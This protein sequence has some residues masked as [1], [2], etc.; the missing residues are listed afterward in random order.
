MKEYN[1]GLY[2]RLSHEDIEDNNSIEAQRVI[3][4]EY[5]IKHKYNI[6]DEYVDNGYSGMLDSRPALNRMIVD[7]LS[8]KINMVIVKDI[9]RLT[10]DKNKTGYF[11]EIFFPDND[12]R[13]ISVTE[14]IDSGYRY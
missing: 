12:I 7:I 2:L 13:F 1:A 11:T 8:N 3:T 4:R 9:S 14:M 10:R 6:I 5:A